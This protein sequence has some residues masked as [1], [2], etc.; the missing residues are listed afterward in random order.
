MSH[1]SFNIGEDGLSFYHHGKVFQLPRENKSFNTVVEDLVAGRYNQAIERI[2]V[3]TAIKKYSAG[4]FTVENGEVLHHG[5]P[6]HNVLTTRILDMMYEGRN[7]QAMLNFMN[8][9]NNNSSR[10]AR[11]ELYLFL[12][13]NDIPLT[14][15]GCFLAYKFVNRDYMDCYT[16]TISNRIGDTPSMPRR[17]VDDNRERTC[18]AGLHFCSHSY[19]PQYGIGDRHRVMKVKV[20]PADVV[21]I[22]SDYNNAKGRTWRYEVVGEIFDWD[23]PVYDDAVYDSSGNTLEYD[24]GYHDGLDGDY[25]PDNEN[26]YY[27][28]D[29]EDYDEDWR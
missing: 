20:N 2:D 6:F 4:A 5:K 24:R 29:P 28:D 21:A 12:E 22:P 14:E 18:S 17:D 15:D 8:N 19:L 9:L 7:V 13:A 11:E 16:G 3:A 1:I 27:E 10:T 25:D 26:D 23:K